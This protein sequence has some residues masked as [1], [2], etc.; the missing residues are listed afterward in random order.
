[1]SNRSARWK[2]LI[3]RQHQ[4]SVPERKETSRALVELF[5]ALATALAAGAFEQRFA[6]GIEHDA[7]RVAVYLNN[8]IGPGSA[9][10]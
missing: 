7:H 10:G 1:L 4:S 5:F 2:R 9:A 8:R 6:L 3:K